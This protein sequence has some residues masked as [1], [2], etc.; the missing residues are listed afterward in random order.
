MNIKTLLTA[1]AFL[2]PVSAFANGAP[3]V[4]LYGF[5]GLNF[6]ETNNGLDTTKPE[7]A[8][9]GVRGKIF[10]GYSGLFLGGE[11]TYSD[12]DTEFD[13]SKV[14]YESDEYRIGGGVL[15]PVSP[16]FRLGGYGHYVSQQID[17]SFEGFT[18][19]EEA[20]GY[21]FGALFEY[22]ASRDVQTYGRIGYI[23]LSP[24]GSDSD[25]DEVNGVDLLA[26]LSFRINRSLSLFGEYRYT[27]LE[28]D[29][30]EQDYNSIRAGVRLTY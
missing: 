28:N 20:S 30:A 29:V 6:I 10:L 26:G 14:T 19:T 23:A 4:D 15:L 25:A 27:Y 13:N 8:D 17:T 7:G 22:D 3:G 5:A 9:L 12:T 18:V 1:A 16:V 21:D 11:Y 24:D 2:A